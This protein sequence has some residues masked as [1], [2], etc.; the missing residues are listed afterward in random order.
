MGRPLRCRL[1]IHDYVLREEP[2]TDRYLACSRCGKEWEG[3]DR[4]LY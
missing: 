4:T 3:V 1:G 2:G